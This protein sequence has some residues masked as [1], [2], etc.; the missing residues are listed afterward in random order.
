MSL[1]N[2]EFHK[3]FRLNQKLID[4]CKQISSECNNFDGLDTP[5]FIDTEYDNYSKQPFIYYA[6]LNSQIIGF[7]SVYIIDAHNAEICTFVLPQYRRN[8]IASNLFA[9]MVADYSSVSFQVSLQSDNDFGKYFISQMGFEYCSTECSMQL[10][11]D[12][13]ISNGNLL[14]LNPEKQEDSIIVRG[15]ADGA[16]IGSCVISVFDNIVCIHDV[17]VYEA[18]RS[19]GYGHKLITTLLNHVFEKYDSA[20]LHVTKEN[21]PA[22]RLYKKA[23]FEV[24]QELEYYEV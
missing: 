21:E 15:L 16:E 18:Y 17:E 24:V 3:S 23:G 11:K 5:F 10:K 8:K 13:F 22:Y 2:I 1:T 6:V 7:L 12:Q 20:V 4:S 9:M 19:K 14:S